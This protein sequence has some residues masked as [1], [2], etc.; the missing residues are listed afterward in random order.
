MHTESDPKPLQSLIV[1]LISNRWCPALHPPW[2]A[3]LA[4][5]NLVQAD[6]RAFAQAT[7]SRP[8]SVGPFLPFSWPLLWCHEGHLGYQPPLH[9]ALP[10]CCLADLTYYSTCL[11]TRWRSVHLM[12]SRWEQGV[13]WLTSSPPAPASSITCKWLSFKCAANWPGRDGRFNSDYFPS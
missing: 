8:P 4:V 13:A 5:Q 2:L 9:S 1:L 11:D 3:S 10:P 7:S 12:C 6:P